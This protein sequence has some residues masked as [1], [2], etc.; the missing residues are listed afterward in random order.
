M[1]I[2]DKNLLE[3]LHKWKLGKISREEAQEAVNKS[4]S[5]IVHLYEGGFSVRHINQEATQD[6]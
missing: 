2:I 5:V 1:N 4:A 3:I 6:V